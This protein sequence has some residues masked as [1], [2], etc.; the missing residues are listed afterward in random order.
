MANVRFHHH[1]YEELTPKNGVIV[2]P[3][4][5][6]S[7]DDVVMGFGELIGLEN[8]LAASRMNRRVVLFCLKSDT[9]LRRSNPAGE[10]SQFRLWLF[11]QK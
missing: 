3:P 8:I 6:V 4:D 11:R 1:V 10:A 7:V 5:G 9:L 2:F